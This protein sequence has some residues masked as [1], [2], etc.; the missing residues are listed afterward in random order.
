MSL[1]QFDEA[2]QIADV[3]VHAVEAFRDDQRP[4]VAIA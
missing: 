3:A 2:G 1:L 4:L